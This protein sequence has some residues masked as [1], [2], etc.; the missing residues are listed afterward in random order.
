MT[1]WVAPTAA[2]PVR[3][4]VIVPGSKSATARAHV[5]AAL[6]DGPSRLVGA[7]DARDTR[8]MRGALATLGVGYTDHDDGTVTVTPPDAFRP[9]AVD[10]GLA[11]TIM[12]FV[13]PL[14]ALAE[15]TTAFT[16]DREA[17]VRPVAPLLDGLAQAGAR[18]DGR[19]LPFT[20]HGTGSVRGGEATIDASGSSQFVSGLLLSAARFDEGLTLHHRGEAVP[21]RPHI[22]LTLAMLRDRGVGAE[23]VGPASWRV[24]PGPIDARDETIEPDLV[25]AAVFLA[26]ALPTAGAVTVAW[27]RHTVQAA[28]TILG[29]LDALG[30]VV[31]RTDGYV[32]VSGTGRVKGADLDLTDASELTCIAAALL[33]TAD[34]PGSIRG[35]AHIRGHE[36]DR[37][38]ALET[39]LSQRGAGVHQTADGLAIE[40]RPLAGGAWGTYA[41]H[42]MAHAG[43]V[44]GLSVPGVELDDIGATTKTMADFAGLWSGLVGA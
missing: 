38:A 35:V 28:D 31:T 7:L 21:S 8:L 44:L 24:E 39:E 5:L 3:G 16:G 36:T 14:A 1:R 12:R 40:P 41:D 23:E 18:I 25:N 30:G 29:V 19:A 20:V 43:A 15:G 10:V 32:T 34:G 37:L 17:E 22:G 4:S 6:A 2:G 13:P 27:P 42:R 11:G 26:A 33:A 9:G